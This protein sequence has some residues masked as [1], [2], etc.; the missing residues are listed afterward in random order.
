MILP[1]RQSAN[2]TNCWRNGKCRKAEGHRKTGNGSEPVS[3]PDTLS[4]LGISKR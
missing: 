3:K 2:A 1:C 4:S